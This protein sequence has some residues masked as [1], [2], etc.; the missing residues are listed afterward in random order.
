[1][2]MMMMMMMMKPVVNESAFSPGT[3]LQRLRTTIK[4]LRI[5]DAPAEIQT[6]PL[7]N[8]SLQRYSYSNVPGLEAVPQLRRLVAG[9]SPRRPW[10]EPRSGHVRFVVNK[11]ALGKVFSK[12]F[13]FPCQV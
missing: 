7:Q 13:G 2:M 3:C 11:V 5:A 12:Y 6:H 10:F 9:F 1:M 4:H 8:T